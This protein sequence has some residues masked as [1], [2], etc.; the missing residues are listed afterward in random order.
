MD[1][2]STRRIQGWRCRLESLL[3]FRRQAENTWRGHIHL[4]PCIPPTI[5]AGNKHCTIAV[6]GS[7]WGNHGLQH[8]LEC[9]P[10][11]GGDAF[12][13][14]LMGRGR[15]Q[16]LHEGTSHHQLAISLNAPRAPAPLRYFGGGQDEPRKTRPPSHSG[17]G[18][19]YEPPR[20]SVPLVEQLGL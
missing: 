7:D 14:G 17:Q 3:D 13:L 20:A 10:Q 4:H 15:G 5:F 12:G 1:C 11:N 19:R 8:I 9:L 2:A 16:M 6:Q 18:A